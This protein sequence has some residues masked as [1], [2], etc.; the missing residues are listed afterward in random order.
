MQLNQ[1]AGI[2]CV[3]AGVI[4]LVLQ[5]EYSSNCASINAGSLFEYSNKIRGER[6]C[7]NAI[8]RTNEEVKIPELFSGHVDV[9]AV[10]KVQRRNQ[11]H[12]SQ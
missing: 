12:K 7:V 10:F 9:V 11:F 8:A 1:Q 4:N 3:G 6:L 2:L 5:I